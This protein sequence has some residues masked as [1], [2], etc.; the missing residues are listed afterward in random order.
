MLMKNSMHYIMMHTMYWLD[1]GRGS[2]EHV[3][4]TGNGSWGTGWLI[5]SLGD[6]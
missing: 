2:S 6:I 4:Q 3:V 1:Y 5:F